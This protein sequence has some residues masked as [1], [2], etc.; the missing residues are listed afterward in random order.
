MQTIE[1][2]DIKTFMQLLF[3]TDALD[4]YEFVSSNLRTDMTYSLDGHINPSFFSEE[5]LATFE[6][7]SGYLPWQIAKEKV[8]LLIKGK[9]TPSELKIVL[10]ASKEETLL[11]LDSIHSSLHPND[12]DGIFLNILFSENKLTVICGASYNIFSMDKGVENEFA[13]KIVTLFKSYHITC[14]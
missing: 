3:Q 10:K 1:I 13:A 4:S 2:L 5:E 6:T 8:F 9:K 14:S 12:I 7:S 11:L